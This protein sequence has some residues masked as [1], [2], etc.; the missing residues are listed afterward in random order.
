MAKDTDFVRVFGERVFEIRK[1]II[2][3]EAAIPRKR[4]KSKKRLVNWDEYEQQL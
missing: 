4:K 1:H 2:L 3:I